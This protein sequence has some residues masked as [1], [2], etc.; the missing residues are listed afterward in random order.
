MQ[1]AAADGK[2]DLFANRTDKQLLRFPTLVDF[3]VQPDGRQV[4]VV[5]NDGSFARWR[6]AEADVAAAATG[7]VRG[8][9]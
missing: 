8:E 5:V 2:A 6:K 4:F 9:N 1:A 3:V 7:H